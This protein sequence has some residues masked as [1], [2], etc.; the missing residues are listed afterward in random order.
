MWYS[1]TAFDSF[2]QCRLKYKFKY[3]D[4]EERYLNSVESFLGIRVHDSLEKLYRDM[5]F[6]KL[7]SLD[8]LVEFYN[9]IWEK[10]WNDSIHIV[11]DE[12]SK[13]HYK[14]TGEKYIR[15]YYAKY[16][17]FDQDKTIDLESK[18]RFKIDDNTEIFG[19]IDR[20]AKLDEEIFVIHDYKTTNKLPSQQEVDSDRQ[21]ALYHMGVL[22]KWP[23]IKEVKFRYHFLAFNEEMESSRTIEQLEDTRKE[24][25]E[26]INE[27]RETEN[28]PP[29]ET[30]LCDWCEFQPICPRRKHLF[31][32]D[33]L[34]PEEYK[35][36]DGVKLVNEYAKLW[37]QEKELKA[38]IEDVK[39]RICDHA[40][41]N[42]YNAL[43]GS[44]F[45]L[46]I[47]VGTE[48]RFPKKGNESYQELI[49]FLMKVGKY[50]EVSSLNPWGLKK[51][52]ESK[53]WGAEL[54][55]KIKDWSFM[56]ENN[57]V[58]QP[59]QLKGD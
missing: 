59:Y 46:Y 4:G 21:L 55:E 20:L 52:I 29:N 2:Q 22:D 24:V 47:K 31:H 6:S 28:F 18:I 3:I 39:N 56:A 37:H 43:K 10:H 1:N 14:V 49:N 32:V 34:L 50:E 25:K 33:S 40:R 23:S 15:D 58:S 26:L 45:K 30:P 19:L 13:E 7:L 12:Y 9:K 11:K 48:I 17:P 42:N 51:I 35:E 53:A 41:K 5:K 38:M 54:S 27:I 8:E 57:W 44:D 36:E 16:S